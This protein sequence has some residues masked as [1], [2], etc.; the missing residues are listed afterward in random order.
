MY[1]IT[2]SKRIM[3]N[4]FLL[5]IIS[6][7]LFYMQTDTNIPNYLEECTDEPHIL[8]LGDRLHPQQ[9]FVIAN[10]KGLEKPNLL[11][12]VDTCFKMFYVMDVQ[13]LWKCIVTWEFLQKVVYCLEDEAKRKTTPAVISMRAVLKSKLFS[14]ILTL[15]SCHWH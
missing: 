15:A 3:H 9:V 11:K 6:L 12:V 5:G 2:V 13:Y 10:G 8:V 14:F 7:S 1:Q 4:I